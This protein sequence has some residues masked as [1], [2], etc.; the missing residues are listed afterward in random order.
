M[1]FAML[2]CPNRAFRVV[3][4]AGGVGVVLSLVL[5]GWFHREARHLD[6]ARFDRMT[7]Q[8]ADYL[9]AHTE[10]IEG[11]LRNLA[12]ALSAQAE[13][14]SA[15]WDEFMDQA[16]PTWNFPGVVAIGYATN[17]LTGRVL[18]SLAPWLDAPAPREHRELFTLQ[19]PMDQ[20]RRWNAWR[21]E[22][23]REG[24]TPTAPFVREER[25]YSNAGKDFKSARFEMSPGPPV[26]AAGAPF[27]MRPTSRHGLQTIFLNQNADYVQDATVREE[28][29]I[30]Q[31]SSLLQRTNGTRLSLAT[32]L[33]PVLHPRRR[34]VWQTLKPGVVPEAQYEKH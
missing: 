23:Y 7:H 28:V 3:W 13:P 33:A 4:I 14:S 27:A 21:V 9:D 31:D 25:D 29:K 34:E 12:R 20:P 26:F 11:L 16:S 24:V 15:V 2:A 19:P 22:V 8:W 5:A 1:N 18:E 32:M 10:K 6:Q 17:Q 30:S